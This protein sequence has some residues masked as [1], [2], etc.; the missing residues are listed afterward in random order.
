MLGSKASCPDRGIRAPATCNRTDCRHAAPQRDSAAQD[1]RRRDSAAQDCRYTGHGRR[2][3]V[4]A[5]VH[6]VVPGC[7]RKGSVCVVSLGRRTASAVPGFPGVGLTA[8]AIPGPRF[9][10]STVP[11][12][13]SRRLCRRL[14]S[15][16]LEKHAVSR[17][18]TVG[19]HAIEACLLPLHTRLGPQTSALPRQLARVAANARART[20]RAGRGAVNRGTPT[21]PKIHHRPDARPGHVVGENSSVAAS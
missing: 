14:P 5:H 3:D 11:S 17:L 16:V 15:A 20:H 21:A 12:L 19:A 18:S 8:L 1:S 2:S 9:F 13:Q 10:V 4:G 7:L 6:F